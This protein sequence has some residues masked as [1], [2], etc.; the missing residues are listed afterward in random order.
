MYPTGQQSVKYLH[1]V[2]A[3]YQIVDKIQLNTDIT[4]LRCIEND[5]EWEVTLA[6]LVP[7]M[8]DL[9]EHQR[10]QMV[11]SNGRKSVYINR[12][13]VRAK[14]VVSYVG[15]HVE[16]NTWPT[17]VPG[18]DVFKG[19]IFHS[20]RYST[21]YPSRVLYP[22]LLWVC[23]EYSLLKEVFG[24]AHR[25][26]S[27]SGVC[28]PV[29]TTGLDHNVHLPR[30]SEEKIEANLDLRCLCRTLHRCHL[31][32]SSW[33]WL[34]AGGTRYLVECTGGSGIWSHGVAK[35]S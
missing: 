29:T 23:C 30:S 8:G 31:G 4:E 5:E 25:L 19:D 2:V 27:R 22:L 3:K 17:T 21:M 12:E 1:G 7:G 15:I 14:I 6:Y 9:S 10:R 11:T 32:K 18:C 24:G 26:I 33:S 34:P 13:K 20:A 16:P 35:A 28:S